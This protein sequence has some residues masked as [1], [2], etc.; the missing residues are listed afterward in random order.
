M[1]PLNRIATAVLGM[2]FGYGG[3]NEMPPAFTLLA[4]AHDHSKTQFRSPGGRAH[5][6]WRLERS[7]G[8]R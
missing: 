3:Y 7:S 6:K 5:R 1:I 8:R 2:I 4:G